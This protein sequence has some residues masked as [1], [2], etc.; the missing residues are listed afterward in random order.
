V[1]TV[2]TEKVPETT[3]SYDASDPT[4]RTHDITNWPWWGTVALTGSAIAGSIGLGTILVM[5]KHAYSH[6]MHPDKEDWLVLRPAPNGR[7]NYRLS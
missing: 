1:T 4:V 7:L 5:A 2:A 3:F 6:Y